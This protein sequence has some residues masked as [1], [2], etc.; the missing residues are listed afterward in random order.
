MALPTTVIGAYPKPPCVPVKD[1]FNADS[2]MSTSL[3]TRR[4]AADV[5]RAGAGAEALF[6]QAAGEV[7]AD[8]VACGVDVVTDG[9]VRR[10]NYIHYQ[11]R[12]IEGFDFEHLTPRSTRDGGWVVEMPSIVGPVRARPGHFLPHDW[13]VAQN[14]SPVPVKVT[15]PG[16]LTIMDSSA[17]LHYDDRRRLGR[18]LAIALNHEIRALADAGCRYIQVDEPLFARRVDDAL[19]FGI[20]NLERCFHGVPDGVTRVMHMCCGYPNHLD[21]SDYPKADHRAYLRLAP[22]LEEIAID[23]VSIEDAHR[24]N[25]LALLELFRRKTVIFGC[26]AVARSTVE[27]SEG[28]RARL[29]EALEHIDATRLVAAPD[30][31]LGLL[32]SRE[33]A[34]AKLRVLCEAAHSLAA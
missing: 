10:E 32:G 23:Q 12:H 21:Q 19:D 14:A 31:G 15:V 34:M 7:I 29:G 30:C 13:R 25:D 33:L 18:D 8:Q 4:Y 5:E 1:W 6:A 22:A 28:I 27:S 26:V 11:C 3:A 2:T 24:P 16:P 17:D 20:E 9:E